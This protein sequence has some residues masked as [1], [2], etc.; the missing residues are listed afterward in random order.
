MKNRTKLTFVIFWEHAKKYRLQLFLLVG[1][2]VI[3]DAFS[4]LAPYWYK[5]FFD[6]IVVNPSTQAL[7]SILMVIFLF[8]LLHWFWIRVATFAGAY[9]QGR[10]MSDLANT[11]FAY[12]HDHSF[13]F[14][15]NNFVGSLVKRVNRFSRAFQGVA[16][17]LIWDLLPL[18]FNVSVIIIALGFRQKILAF[19]VLTWVV[20]FCIINY[21]FTRYK[22]PFDIKKSELDSKVTG[23]LADTVT[24]QANVKLFGGLKREK[25][26]FGDVIEEWRTVRQ[27]SWNLGNVFD[28]IQ[29][30]L[31]IILE[32]VL[33]IIAVRLW[34]RGA[35]TIGDFVLIQAYLMRIF[36][37]LWNF[38]RTIRDLYENIADAVEMTEILDTPHEIVD[39]PRAKPLHVSHASIEYKNL[40][41]YYHQTRPVIVD[42]QLTIRE[43][44]RLAFVGPSGAGKSTMIQLLL[45]TIEPA[46]GNILIDNQNI[47]NVTQESLRA[48][49]SFVPQEP[50]LFHR[51]LRDNIRY[52]R[53][54]ASDDEVREAAQHAFCDEFITSFPEGYD[55]F[56]GERG[57]KLSGGERQRVALARAFLKN[58]PILVL[59]E[60]TSSL[61]SES[62]H[63]IQGAL[64][65]LMQGKTVIVIAHRLSTIMNMDR[66]VVIDRGQ[67]VEEGSHQHLTH[68]KGL[69]NQL[70]QRQV[71][72]F[73]G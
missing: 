18:L 41:F 4:L 72:G 61:D 20:V 52:G 5:K 37:K 9:F 71:G 59:D 6:V 39:K 62:E 26:L 65:R 47:A 44:E 66:I 34:G 30:F 27:F 63:L 19:V 2:I 54:E 14:F 43:G 42:L 23:V 69:Y 29:W 3:G 15:Q 48:A 60:A 13:S 16:D 45:R 24:N 73:I 49:I 35:L 57:I 64:K 46:N 40:S 25:K 56:V 28:S 68:G 38:G 50:I 21:F 55:T 70:W 11:C 22:L 32:I 17:R 1:S 31:M 51:T 33:M 67:I 53:P 12:L 10:V 58:S 36:E 7:L 8:N